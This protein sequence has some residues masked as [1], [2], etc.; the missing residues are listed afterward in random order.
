[1]HGDERLAAS[2]GGP[3]VCHVCYGFDRDSYL[4]VLHTRVLNMTCMKNA[5][6]ILYWFWNIS[7]FIGFSIHFCCFL[8]CKSVRHKILSIHILIEVAFSF[9]AVKLPLK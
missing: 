8:I 4:N 9:C 7:L 1:M 5:P 6:K 3:S 2:Y